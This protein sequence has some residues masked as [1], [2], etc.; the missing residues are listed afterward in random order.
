MSTPLIAVCGAPRTGKTT[1][2]KKIAVKESLI[3]KE[4]VFFFSPHVANKKEDG[5]RFINPN[6]YSKKEFV[7]KLLSLKNSF[8]ILDDA[9]LYNSMDKEGS[10]IYKLAAFRGNS[11]NK[12]YIQFHSLN[13]LPPKVPDLFDKFILFAPCE[14]KVKENKIPAI[15]REKGIKNPNKLFE[16]ISYL[17]YYL[18]YLRKCDFTKEELQEYKHFIMVPL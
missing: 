10:L 18:K 2:L 17:D 8:I 13:Q 7:P 16:N 6:L 11:N 1:F 9:F 4:H 14:Q 3:N 5:V 15:L 12:I